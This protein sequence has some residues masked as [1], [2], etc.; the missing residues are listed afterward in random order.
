MKW[1]LRKVAFSWKLFAKVLSFALFGLGAFALGTALYPVLFLTLRKPARFRPVM[2]RAVSLSFRLFL[3]VLRVVGLVKVRIVHPERLA[4]ARGFIVVANHPSLIDVVI[5]IAHLPN[6]DCIVKAKLWKTPFVGSVVRKLYISNSLDL[7]RTSEACK[8]SLEEGNC[9]IIFPEGTRTK[10]DSRTPS[11]RRGFAHVALR[12]ESP[13]L[14]IRIDV[15]SAKGLRK[16]DPFL[17]Y[18]EGS[19]MSFVIRPGLPVAVV[20]CSD[21]RLAIHARALTERVRTDIFR[22]YP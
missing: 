18:K 6:S 19:P 9:V 8:A 1:L 3:F 15:D 14:P 12:A 21:G 10:D 22:N 2:R 5:L 17:S 7:E 13:V 16:G 4:A 11:L 20:D